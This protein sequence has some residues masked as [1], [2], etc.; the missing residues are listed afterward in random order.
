M[1][2][3][4]ADLTLILPAGSSLSAVLGFRASSLLSATR[5]KPI[6]PDLAPTI[7]TAIQKTLLGGGIPPAAI[8]AEVN[9]KGR[10]KIEWENFII[11]R[12][13]V[14]LSVMA[15]GFMTLWPGAP[16]PCVGARSPWQGAL[17]PP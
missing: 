11:L 14:I 5:L 3:N 8:K 7:A 17:S 12:Y 6:A 15:V 10:A 13:A 2:N 16:P 4:K 9:A 1:E